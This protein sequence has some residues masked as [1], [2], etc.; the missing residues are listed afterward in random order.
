MVICGHQPRRCWRIPHRAARKRR[1]SRRKA[2]VVEAS[3]RLDA[4]GRVHAARA[5]SDSP[6]VVDVSPSVDGVAMRFEAA[7][8]WA[9]LPPLLLWAWWLSRKSYAQLSSRARWGSLALRVAI[10]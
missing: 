10:L 3:P 8:F 1:R 2:H 6:G 7:W 5:R 9:A 4:L